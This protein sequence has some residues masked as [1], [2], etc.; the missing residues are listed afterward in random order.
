[1]EAKNLHC[2]RQHRGHLEKNWPRA[3]I[4]ASIASISSRLLGCLL[5]SPPVASIAWPFTRP[6]SR[7]MNNT[8]MGLMALIFDACIRCIYDM[9][10]GLG[11]RCEV[12]NQQKRERKNLWN[13]GASRFVLPV[14]QSS[15]VCFWSVSAPPFEQ[16]HACFWSTMIILS[17]GR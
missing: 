14:L 13:E 3:T 5:K 17:S 10:E 15:W 12:R 1:M 6:I 11:F 4:I 16:N 7:V 2:R 9:I 8:R